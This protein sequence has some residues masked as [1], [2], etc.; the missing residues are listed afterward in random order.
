MGG[1]TFQTKKRW[2]NQLCVY[3]VEYYATVQK[4]REHNL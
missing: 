2:L 1:T 4:S 3:A